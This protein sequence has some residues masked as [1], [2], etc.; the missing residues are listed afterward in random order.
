MAREPGGLRR[1]LATQRG[2][3]LEKKNKKTVSAGLT[4][5]GTHAFKS[6]ES[7]C[8]SHHFGSFHKPR[9]HGP[10][11]SSTDL[12]RRREET[13]EETIQDIEHVS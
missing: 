1:L 3:G 8:V 11:A 4:L 10:S 12:R 6:S 9:L 7:C 13:A 2:Q 5:S